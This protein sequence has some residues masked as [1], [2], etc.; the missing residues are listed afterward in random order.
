MS[1]QSAGIKCDH[2][3]NHMYIS[4]I[5]HTLFSQDGENVSEDLV[6]ASGHDS[7]TASPTNS[8]KNLLEHGHREG[9]K[10]LEAHKLLRKEKLNVIVEHVSIFMIYGGNYAS[11]PFVK[12]D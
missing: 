2:Y 7:K 8:R 1:F 9:S 12:R 3:S 10:Y 6:S 4:L 5:L 11:T